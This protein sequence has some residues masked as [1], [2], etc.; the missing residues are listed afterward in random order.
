VFVRD[1]AGGTTIRA[2]VGPHGKQALG[3][4]FTYP[5]GFSATGRYLEQTAS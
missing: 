2:S 1:L 4:S 3:A 5:L